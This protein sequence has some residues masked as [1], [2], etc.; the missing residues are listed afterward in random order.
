MVE[1]ALGRELP[2]AGAALPEPAKRMGVREHVAALVSW[3]DGLDRY[4]P[5]KGPL[6][7]LLPQLAALVRDA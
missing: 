1:A 6:Q 4:T 2:A 7:R 5:M 3:A